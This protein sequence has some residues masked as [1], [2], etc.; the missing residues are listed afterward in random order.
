MIALVQ[1][2]WQFVYPVDLAPYYPF[3]SGGYPTW[4]VVAAALLLVGISEVA[5]LSRRAGRICR[6][7]GF[8]YVGMLS[9]VLGLIPV[10][11]HALADR[12]M[13]LP[14]IGL[15]V[16]LA[17]TLARLAGEVSQRRW[18]VGGATALA[19]VAL[20]VLSWRQTTYWGDD[21]DLWTHALAVT[22]DNGKAEKALGDAPASRDQLDEAIE[23]YRRATKW[24]PD[25]E[26]CNN[27]GISRA[28]ATEQTE[29]SGTALPPGARHQ[30]ERRQC[31]REPRIL[32]G[33]RRTFR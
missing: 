4:Q 25:A 29:R 9:P 14:G 12:Y 8:W 20:V 27:L 21:V 1:Y 22:E 2:L 28:S 26:L 13:Y 6:S 11:Q 24:P 17:W 33:D 10:S 18:A 30:S 3:P 16:A 15:Y 19:L 5:I 31:P 32:F 7:A 23:H